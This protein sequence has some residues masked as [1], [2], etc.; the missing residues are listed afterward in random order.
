MKEKVISFCRRRRRKRS[1]EGS[2]QILEEQVVKT[3]EGENSNVL[4]KIV[5][6]RNV[7]AST[8]L[9]LFEEALNRVP[10]LADVKHLNALP[11]HHT[12]RN[13][14]RMDCQTK[15]TILNMLVEA[16]P[17]GLVEGDP[18]GQTPL[19][20]ACCRGNSVKEIKLLIRKGEQAAFVKDNKGNL[21]IHI[22]LCRKCTAEKLRV[23]Y[24]V[25][26]QSL[27]A[28]NNRGYNPITLASSNSE[29]QLNA[30]LIL[31]LKEKLLDNAPEMGDDFSTENVPNVAAAPAATYEGSP[32]N[33]GVKNSSNKTTPPE[34]KEVV[35][36]VC[37]SDSD[38]E[39]SPSHQAHGDYK[40]D[41][42]IPDSPPVTIHTEKPYSVRRDVMNTQDYATSA[43][44]NPS[45]LLS[46]QQQQ[47]LQLQQQRQSINAN[48]NASPHLANP[49]LSHHHHQFIALD[50][51]RLAAAQAAA[52]P[53]QFAM[54]AGH[55]MISIPREAAAQFA[56]TPSL[57][58]RTPLSAAT[59]SGAPPSV[60]NMTGRQYQVQQPRVDPNMGPLVENER[61]I[62]EKIINQMDESHD[63]LVEDMVKNYE[64]VFLSF[65]EYRKEETGLQSQIDEINLP[66][67]TEN[68]E[69]TLSKV[70]PWDEL[71][72]EVF[73]LKQDMFRKKGDQEPAVDNLRSRHSDEMKKKLTSHFESISAIKTS[74]SIMLLKQKNSSRGEVVSLNAH[75]ENLS[76]IYDR[77]IIEFQEKI[78]KT[79]K[80]AEATKYEQESRQEKCTKM[81]IDF[82]LESRRLTE[83]TE[84][85]ILCKKRVLEA[86]IEY[87]SSKLE[88]KDEIKSALDEELLDYK[89]VDTNVCEDDKAGTD[90]IMLLKA[91]KNRLHEQVATLKK[92]IGEEAE[93]KAAGD[94]SFFVE[95]NKDIDMTENISLMDF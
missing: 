56:Q 57:A 11:I 21:P 72:A 17:Q 5:M 83:Y 43:R 1:E 55:H 22:A 65:E 20:I 30:S 64:N 73:N 23:L 58:Q 78:K 19:H 14:G 63:K 6:S 54:Q 39:S 66:F 9:W 13:L 81:N 70:D 26:P 94:N 34:Q 15:Y 69:C 44:A 27:F 79:E 84:E 3:N 18:T 2:Y 52:F 85:L 82:V 10:E 45:A 89:E 74:H 92:I 95:V 50:H 90:M 88:K 38:D 33:G 75:H 51:H 42:Y 29:S 36:L 7:D 24:N 60:T 48:I 77:N 28:V 12:V 61:G 62:H 4:S 93:E 67:Q 59:I 41:K 31:F 35:D 37:T 86:R 80:D 49:P 76:N 87:L 16:Y 40:D 68:K 71:K 25:H 47:L 53:N 46:P 32:T 8:R 91:D